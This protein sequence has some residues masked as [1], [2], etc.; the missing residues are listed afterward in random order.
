MII[1][2]IPQNDIEK[3]I[4]EQLANFLGILVDDV[5]NDDDL[6]EDLH[7]S[8]SEITD[9]IHSIQSRGYTLDMSKITDLQTVTDIIEAVS[10][11]IDF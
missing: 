3:S 1:N 8:S 6:K 7:M 2:N 10:E 9:F 4:K 5:S 11:E